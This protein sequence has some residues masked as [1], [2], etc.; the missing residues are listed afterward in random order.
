MPSFTGKKKNQNELI[1]MDEVHDII[2][3]QQNLESYYEYMEFQISGYPAQRTR[4]SAYT[5]KY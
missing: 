2:A 3:F 4:R 5:L 1:Q